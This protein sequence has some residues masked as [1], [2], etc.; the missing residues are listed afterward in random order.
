M[1]KSSRISGTRGIGSTR[2]DIILIDGP[3]G[4]EPDKPGRSLP[5]YWAHKYSD[6]HTH[7]F[8]DD[9]ERPLE[10]EYCD[11]FLGKARASTILPSHGK[12]E[13]F[14]RI[15]NGSRDKN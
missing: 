13:M 8:V 10:R 15:G 4:Y 1:R 7:I 9:Y 5:I 6:P 3:A 14:W 2:W 12:G 11:F